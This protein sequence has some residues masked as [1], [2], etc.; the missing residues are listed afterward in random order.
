MAALALA[1]WLIIVPAL[2]DRICG[3]ALSATEM[4]IPANTI[5]L[6]FESV[7]GGVGLSGSG[8]ASAGL[9]CGSVSAYGST[10]AG[11]TR[12]VGA[13]SFT[14]STPF[15]V[16]VDLDSGT[17]A[18]YSLSAA[19]AVADTTNTWKIS[20]VTLNTSSQTIGAVQPYGSVVSYTIYLTVPFASPAGAI[21]NS[22]DLLAVAD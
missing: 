4:A 8:T 15:G 17:S 11:V 20:S 22:V 10:P 5:S 13:D 16:Q 12:T 19:L 14:V 18:S 7:V 6:R 9:N 1:A 2:S 21:N 3:A